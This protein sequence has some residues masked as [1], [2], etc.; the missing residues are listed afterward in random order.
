[1]FSS[2]IEQLLKAE[3]RDPRF[4]FLTAIREESDYSGL[5]P[6]KKWP[7]ASQSFYEFYQLNALPRNS[8]SLRSARTVARATSAELDKKSLEQLRKPEAFYSSANRN[9]VRRV[10]AERLTPEAY[11]ALFPTKRPGRIVTDFSG[12][13]LI[14]F[15]LN[16]TKISDFPLPE[17][18]MVRTTHPKIEFLAREYIDNKTPKQVKSVLDRLARG[19]IGVGWLRDRFCE[20]AECREGFTYKDWADLALDD[21]GRPFVNELLFQFR[22]ELANLYRKSKEQPEG[23]QHV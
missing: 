1:M 8:A 15:Y 22:L 7:G 3:P 5:Y 9:R 18:T 23:N 14:R 10:I 17:G 11:D 16:L 21:E 12:W 20:F 4:Q 19:R 6:H 13:S 2:D